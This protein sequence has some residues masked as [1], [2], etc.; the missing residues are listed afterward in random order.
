[1]IKN[2]LLKVALLLALLLQVFTKASAQYAIGGSA[3][4]NLYNSV[5]WLTWDKNLTGS[6]LISSPD[7]ADAQHVLEGKYV[8]QF[9][10]T[11]RITATISNLTTT[12]GPMMSYTPG[13]YYA[14]GLDLIYSGN[15]KPKPDS[16]G[17]P[18]SGLAASYG[19]TTNF[20]ID[21]IVE[22]YINNQWTNVSYPGMIIADAESIDIGGEYITGTTP[23][24]IAWQLL[25]KRTQ[26]MSGDDH[27]KMELSNGGKTFRLFADL[28]PG[29]FGVQAVM[30]A[31]GAHTLNNVGMKG[32]GLTAMAIGFVLPFDLGD[33]PLGYGITG[34]YI[35]DFQMTD[36]FAGDGIYPV[37]TY[38]TTDL[39]PKANVYIGANNLDPDGQPVGTESAN[40]D[41]TVGNNDESTL[42]PTT[43]PTVKVNQAGDIVL[44]L[45]VTNNKSVPATLYS[46]LDFN[47]DGIF[48]IDEAL[49]YT[50]PANTVNQTITVTYPNARFAGK[51]KVG[52]LYTRFRIT[53]TPLLDNPTTA[54]D[55]RS[56]SFAADGETEDYRFKDI[57]GI[58]I[59]GTVVNDG[60]GA[61]DGA[62]A[63][64]GIQ[65]VAGAPLYAYLV[66]NTG[67]VIAQVPVGTDGTYAFPNVNN[68]NY[69]VAIST[70]NAPVGSPLS[71]VAANLPNG[72][73]PSGASY[74]VN[75]AGHT[76][77]QAGTPNLQ[78]QVSTPGTSLDISGITLGVAQ[79][80]TAK[81]DT[82]TTA[83]GRPVVINVPAND[84]DADGSI[85]VTTVQLVDPAD[86]AKK[87]S[88][89]IPNQGTYTVNT[90]TGQVT[91]TPL[92]TF[93]G[94]TTPI[95]YTVKDNLGNESLNT[96]IYVNV[97][98]AG[99]NDSGITPLDV[100][101]TTTV[102]A[103]DGVSANGTTVTATAGAHGTTAVNAT[104]QLVYTPSLGY[105]GLDTYTYT[106]TT[107]DGLVSD[108]ITVNIT[109]KPVGAND[110]ETTPINTPVTTTVKTNDGPSATGATV[111][112]TP[113]TH[114]TV[115]VDATGR[116]TYTPNPTY[117]GKDIY[118][119]VL[120]TPDGAV[121]DPITVTVNIKPVGV[122]DQI[123]T[124]VNT[125]VTTEVKNN[126]GPSGIGT[127]VTPTRGAHGATT[128]D[129][130]GHVIYTPDAGYTGI[131]TYTYT[132]TTPD[133]VVSDPITVT[134]N[135]YS[136]TLSL[137]KVATN[138]VS[139][140]GDIIN[141]NLVVRN[142]G[143]VVLTNVSVTDIGADAGS[144]TP[145]T[146]ATLQPGAST[147]VTARH[148]VTQADVNAGSFS[149]QA[150][151]SGRDP[152]GNVVTKNKSDN[153][154]TTAVDDPTVVVIT[155][156]GAISLTKTSVFN[157]YYITYTFTIKNT[158]NSVL[159]T[160]LL[161]D[162]KLGMNNFPVT[163]PASGLQPGATVSLTSN[164]TL[165]QADKDAGT[166][167][168]TASVTSVDAGGNTVGNTAG[169]TTTFAK[170]PTA[171][172]D[173]A[174]TSVNKSVVIPVLTNDN[175]GNSNF[176]LTGIEI[177]TQP[178]HGTITTNVNGTVIYTPNPGYSGADIFT[179]RVKD[180]YGFYTNVA[181][182]TI[183]IN[184][185]SLLNVPTL[186]T[187]NG[188]GANDTFEIRGLEQFSENELVIVN[189]WG[190]E[191]YHSTN[192]KNN[193]T[194]E[195]LNEGTYYYILKVKEND[196]QVIKGYITLLRTVKR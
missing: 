187:P 21:I 193:W 142:T 168:N 24:P 85:N 90:T 184:S 138:G 108:P 27:Y 44:R 141:Y 106:L 66:D 145:A 151:V 118:T 104:G 33:D 105:V 135:I 163:I 162:A 68:G 46:W 55:E 189:R 32:S 16:R 131:D 156:P 53:T 41:D 178:A 36:Y 35:D 160:V 132:L 140:A 19:G 173:A 56:T 152:N 102:K 72:W 155:T 92:P 91:F 172:N 6:T 107:A 11:V 34:N 47:G 37:V 18:A 75:N 52:T 139:K 166:V 43:L 150:S 161:T 38:N 133:G 83:V 60:N 50:V 121:S 87:N 146:I 119:Y 2:Y 30:F 103:N 101:I 144:I 97:R 125:P 126:D 148:T 93:V 95:A 159:N 176:D 124:L 25:N 59:S 110:I 129:A 81:S 114:G 120:T 185:V 77:I 127:V 10:P 157:A 62:I 8:W 153:P 39:I 169:T 80:P 67:L 149:N 40:N 94:K 89:T 112:A 12:N 65:A 116:I 82:A 183:T 88:V 96:L 165:T 123:S 79:G 1:M 98:P 134:V 115:V 84:T 100:P 5:Y 186:F 147:T 45:P 70:N 182:G 64:T 130:S 31:R 58:T 175:S 42:T 113:G 13:D 54:A 48:S 111:T 51:I 76:G 69:T 171:G 164:Y 61:S 3:G 17:V 181:T 174:F 177:I 14:D 74:G 196:W 49:Q 20:N 9:S 117:I 99:V 194:G 179:Y 71:A 154:A 188:D 73:Q 23:N 195:G 86:N 191:V 78:V 15:N 170:S 29:N 22:I 190:N 128:V 109:V 137:T 180:L 136:S 63:G 7:G 26:N 57:T 122:N 4:P 28:A 167:V 158:G 192:Y 143:S